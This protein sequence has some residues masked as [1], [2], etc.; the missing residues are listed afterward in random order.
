MLIHA[1]TRLYFSDESGHEQDVLLSSLPPNRRQ[2]LLAIR[3]ETAVMPTYRFDIHMQGERET[4]FF[5]A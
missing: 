2:T 5:D 4:V 3:D 1:V